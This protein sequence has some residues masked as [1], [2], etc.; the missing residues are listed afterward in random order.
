MYFLPHLYNTEDYKVTVDPTD[1]IQFFEVTTM[2][3][4]DFSKELEE[5]AHVF[6]DEHGMQLPNNV[7]KGFDVFLFLIA[8]LEK[9]S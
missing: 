5:F 9:L 8:Q 7:K 1:V 3:S 4:A 2:I 6:M